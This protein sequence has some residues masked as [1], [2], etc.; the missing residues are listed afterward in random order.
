VLAL[1]AQLRAVLAEKETVELAWLE[2]AEA[3]G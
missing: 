3:A 1:D 2:A